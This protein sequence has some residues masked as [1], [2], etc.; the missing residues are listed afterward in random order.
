MIFNKSVL[1]VLLF[2]GLCSS[3]VC[4]GDIKKA[5]HLSKDNNETQRL[6]CYKEKNLKIYNHGLSSALVVHKYSKGS[7]TLLGTDNL[8][9]TNNASVTDP[10][11]KKVTGKIW[12]NY[13]HRDCNE[14]SNEISRNVVVE[15]DQVLASG[16]G[17]LDDYALLSIDPFDFKYANVK[18][19]F[20]GLEVSKNNPDIG[21]DLYITQY[22]NGIKM[23]AR[24]SDKKDGAP[25]TLI[26]ASGVLDYNCEAVS[27]AS[28]AP[29]LSQVSHKLVGVNYSGPLNVNDVNHAMSAEKIMNELSAFI[30]DENN[31]EQLPLQHDIVARQATITPNSYQGELL[32]AEQPVWFTS[33]DP[34]L[35]IEHMQAF[36]LATFMKK[37][38]ATG[39]VKE[40]KTRKMKIWL[41][42]EC[43]EY[44]ID[45][46]P[47]CE[48]PGK[49]RLMYS[50]NMSQQSDATPST[51]RYW[52]IL[53]QHNEQGLKEEEV[54]TF[55]ESTGQ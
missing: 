4:A 40:D 18:R 27:G 25:C 48:I 42:N 38:E 43:G 32:N 41:Q 19:L 51:K 15:I 46:K 47:V 36:S 21:E 23:P 31:R 28:G 5:N 29:V 7:G 26:N 39:V 35:K 53:T 34:E 50:V 1:N 10:V 20:G 37:D 11:G 49:T 17:G 24:V 55:F 22:G 2:S 14:Q 6:V 16:D 33:S 30:T 9:L 45:Q 8:F 13:H 44:S 12:L 3:F 54:I 52:L